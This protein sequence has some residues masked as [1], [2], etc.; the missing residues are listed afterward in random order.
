MQDKRLQYQKSVTSG[1]SNLLLMLV[2]SAVNMVLLLVNASINFPFSAF[3][4]QFAVIMGSS[5]ADGTGVSALTI[6][7]VVLGILS[8]LLYL[9]CYFLAKKQT[10]GMVAALVLFSL[11]T[12]LMLYFALSAFE[13]S[14]LIDIAFHVWV[15]F[16]FASA[17][18]AAGKLKRMPVEATPYYTPAPGY[19][20]APFSV[21]QPMLEEG[22]QENV[23]TDDAFPG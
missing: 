7:G 13:V 2:L 5:L 1:R 19:P 9:V 16:S 17:L 22:T 8:I 11:D 18:V 20:S 12:A 15:L 14:F 21:A 4:P 6:A 3:F 10:G 23:V